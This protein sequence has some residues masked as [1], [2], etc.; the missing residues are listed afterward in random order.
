MSDQLTQINPFD[1]QLKSTSRSGEI[2][3]EMCS[4]VAQSLTFRKDHLKRS[5]NIF[6]NIYFVPFKVIPILEA[7]QKNCFLV[8]AVASIEPI[9]VVA[10][11]SQA[12]I[13]NVHA[14]LFLVETEQLATRLMPKSLIKIE[15]H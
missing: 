14:L 1:E 9:C 7:L 11:R 6:I 13:N 10:D 5:S 2:P 3:A 15:W 4:K 8:R 12:L